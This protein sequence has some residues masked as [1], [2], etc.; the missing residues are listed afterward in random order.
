MYESPRV[1]CSHIW[2]NPLDPPISRHS[3]APII[4]LGRYEMQPGQTYVC[5]NCKIQIFAKHEFE[6]HEERIAGNTTTVQSKYY[7]LCNCGY[8]YPENPFF[9]LPGDTGKEHVAAHMNS[10][11]REANKRGFHGQIQK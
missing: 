4:G 3:Y 10:H 8:R 9:P 1:V 7:A 5:R 2:V 11:V 6:I